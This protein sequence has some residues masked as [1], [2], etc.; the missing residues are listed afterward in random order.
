MKRN[1]FTWIEL[2]VVLGVLL[3]IAAI[4]FPVF[5]R[6]RENPHKGS[7]QSNLKQIGLGFKQYTQDYDDEFP[8]YNVGNVGSTSSGS[9]TVTHWV[10]SLQG[11][12]KSIQIFQCPTENNQI[13]TDYYYSRIVSG[14]LEKTFKHPENTILLTEGTDTS[15]CDL[16]TA[17]APITDGTPPAFAR[18]L[19][20]S[21]YAFVDGHVKWLQSTR[22]PSNVPAS[23]GGFTFN[24]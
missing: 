17:I 1:G 14:K 7:C 3:L 18:H 13:G 9:Y 8:L 21:N 4:L 15:Q 5:A 23:Q 2:L 11:Y 10:Q 19:E 6:S 24:S 22:A 20:G 12:T 16:A